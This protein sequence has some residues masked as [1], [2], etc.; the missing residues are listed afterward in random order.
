MIFV[1]LSAK[2][3]HKTA[4]SA[5][6]IQRIATYYAQVSSKKQTSSRILA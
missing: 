2:S 6:S 5:E 1:E 4:Y 3:L